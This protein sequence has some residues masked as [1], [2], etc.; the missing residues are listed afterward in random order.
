MLINT[1]QIPAYIVGYVAKA[2]VLPS[3]LPSDFSFPA[4]G[5]PQRVFGLLAPHQNMI[6][7]AWVEGDFFDDGEV[8]DIKR[9]RGKTL[10]IWG[11]V[12]YEDVVGEQRHTNFAHNI[13]WIPFKDGTERISG[14]YADRHN[15]AK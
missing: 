1:G 12:T 2:A 13:I 15:D 7:N 9:G 11:T 3:P 10:Y 6:M 4:L 5:Q 8:E 14:Y